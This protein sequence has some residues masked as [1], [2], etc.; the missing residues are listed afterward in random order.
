MI[1]F[2][3]IKQPLFIAEI[4]ANHNGSLIQAK[5]LIKHAKTYGADWVKIQTY[6]ARNMTIKSDRKEFKIKKGLWKNYNLWDLYEKG[7]TPLTWQ[8]ELFRYAK[9]INTKLF[10]SPF[11]I[12]CVDI[13]E[14]VNCPMY[15][16]ASFEMNDYPLIKRIAQTKKPIIIST[17]LASLSEIRKTVDYAKKNGAKSIALLYC[18]SNYPAKITDFNLNN[19]IIMKKRFKDCVIGLS[20]HSLDTDICK[21]AVAVG[22]KIIEKHIALD[23]QKKGLDLAFSLKGKEIQNFKNDIKKSHLLLGKDYFHR[24]KNEKVNL[25]S[26]RSIYSIDKIEKNEKFSEKNIKLIRPA[27]GLAPEYYFKIIGKKSSKTINSGMP[28]RKEFIK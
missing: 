16:V 20:D 21:I 2:K 23:N 13:L 5:K 28:I 24:T 4:S 3:K 26:R 14:T 12:E 22:A 11:D 9:K 8:K 15:K 27:N 10:S 25:K 6:E 18:V 17:G 1:D 7:S 19:I